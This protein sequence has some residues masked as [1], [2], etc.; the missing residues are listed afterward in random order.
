M[1]KDR[2]KLEQAICEESKMA[3]TELVNALCDYGKCSD[4]VSCM[5]DIPDGDLVRGLNFFRVANQQ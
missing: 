4:L 5:S 1:T 3:A 2:Q